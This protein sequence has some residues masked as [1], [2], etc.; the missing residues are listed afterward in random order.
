MALLAGA[1]RESAL[2]RLERT[3]RPYADAGSLPADGGVEAAYKAQLQA[4]EDEGGVE[5]RAQHKHEILDDIERQSGPMNAVTDRAS[6]PMLTSST[7]RKS[8]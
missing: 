6:I 2:E 7:A 5:A 4:A 8:P 1:A 3:A